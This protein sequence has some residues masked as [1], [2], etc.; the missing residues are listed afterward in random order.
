MEIIDIII[1]ALVAIMVILG[2][3]KGFIISLATLAALALGIYAA[4]RFSGFATG[5]IRAHTDISADY[6]PIVSFVVTFVLIMVLVLLLGK[7]LEKLVDVV[8]IG[9]LNHLAG[10]V[11][12]L[13]KGVLLLSLL[14]FLLSF[15]DPGEKLITARAKQESIFY[16]HVAGVLPALLKW[17]GT[18]DI[19]PAPG[20][21]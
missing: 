16:H 21:G 13:V 4:I 7:L 5:L 20:S 19:I 2:F 9:F 15:A 14:F 3:R 6:L 12:G 11:F 1:L 17:T 8:G 18:E 10:G